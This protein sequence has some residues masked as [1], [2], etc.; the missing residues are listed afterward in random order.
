M[1]PRRRRG[2]HRMSA[3]PK[4]CKNCARIMRPQRS[5][6]EDYPTAET[7]H[8]AHG[9]CQACYTNPERK[10]TIPYPKPCVKHERIVRPASSTADLYPTAEPVRGARVWCKARYMH[11]RGTKPANP[12]DQLMHEHTVAVLE[13]FMARVKGKSRSRV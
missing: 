12:L 11:Q 3:Y 7:I 4:P 13:R 9:L 1:V 6:P 2:G 8:Q 10:P 5:S